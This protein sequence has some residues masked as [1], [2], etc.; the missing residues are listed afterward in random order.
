MD[1]LKIMFIA[2]LAFFAIAVVRTIIQWCLNRSKKITSVKDEPIVEVADIQGDSLLGFNKPF[3][4]YACYT[5]PSTSVP[6]VRTFL[7]EISGKITSAADILKY[8]KNFRAFREQA[9]S[10]FE[11]YQELAK[12]PAH[13]LQTSWLNISFSYEAMYKL[14][15]GDEEIL[16][17]FKGNAFTGPSAF[18]NGLPFR[19]TGVLNDRGVGAPENWIKGYSERN[20]D[21]MI[22]I[23]TDNESLTEQK[24]QEINEMATKRGLT[25]V[26]K[27]AGN[28]LKDPSISHFDIGM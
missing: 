15:A 26:H 23:G 9:K 16:K 17:P 19:A 6:Q 27:Q 4:T 21:I 18:E 13:K 2:Y 14:T 3:R 10:K 1:W 20:P 7:K 12:N 25:L 22:H 11:A 5:F 28:V 24:F 8:R